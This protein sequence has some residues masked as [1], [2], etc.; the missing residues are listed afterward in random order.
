MKKIIAV[1]LFF[2]AFNIYSQ[3]EEGESLDVE[4]LAYG[5][6]DTDDFPDV[7][8][9][10]DYIVTNSGGK[11]VYCDSPL[12]W[13]IARMCYQIIDESKEKIIGKPTVMWLELNDRVFY[14]ISID[15]DYA[16]ILEELL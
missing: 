8:D 4:H 9:F 7:D 3:E 2:A 10:A 11:F 13:A 16:V 5:L 1:L 14:F 6:E 12:I 15:G